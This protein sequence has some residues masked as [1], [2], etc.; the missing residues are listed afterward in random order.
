MEL[1]DPDQKPRV[2]GKIAR[3]PESQQ[4]QLRDWMKQGLIYT[5]IQ[6]RARETFGVSIS[7]SSLST[8]YS[9]HCRQILASQTLGDAE[10]L[11]LTL[12]L[13]VQIRAELLHPS[14][15]SD[16]K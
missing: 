6:K 13:H 15:N 16:G 10:N 8:Y 5:E 11:N 3:L 1:I 2:Q 9:K 12:V 4:Q 7:V 14:S